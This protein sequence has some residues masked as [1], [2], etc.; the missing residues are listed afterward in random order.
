MFSNCPKI[1]RKKFEECLVEIELM[2]NVSSRLIENP[3]EMVLLIHQYTKALALLP[4]KMEKRQEE[5]RMDWY[6]NCDNRDTVKVDKDGNGLKR[7]WQQQLCQF[8]LM[9]LETSEAIASV[10]K[11]PLQ[12]MEV[13]SL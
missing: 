1:S 11:C 12:L 8:N 10:Y 13:S 2:H 4:S 6:A 5:S 7:L 3:G 9:S